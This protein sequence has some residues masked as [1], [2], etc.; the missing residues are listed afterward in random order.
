MAAKIA[1]HR[2][3]RP[4]TWPTVEVA[5][6]LV[7]A[8]KTRPDGTLLVEALGTW[9]AAHLDLSPD[10]DGLLAALAARRGDTV[11]V[12]DEV[13]L[14]VHPSTEPGRRFR[15]TLGDINVAVAALADDVVL[16]VAGRVVPLPRA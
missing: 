10:L 2:A 5:A 13:G 4:T 11:L 9:L 12:S 14:G 6:D 16:V 7:G 15:D 8:L 3:R 1:A